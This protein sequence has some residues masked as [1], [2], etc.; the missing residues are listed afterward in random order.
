[1]DFAD[2]N[3]TPGIHP[4]VSIFI[5][6]HLAV[7]PD[8]DLLSGFEVLQ[9][10]AAV[11]IHCATEPCRFLVFDIL[12]VNPFFRMGNGERHE[13]VSVCVINAGILPD[14]SN[15]FNFEHDVF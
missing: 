9:Q 8:K 5:Q 6:L 14:V 2:T 12:I 1:L 7:T 11:T 4:M 3:V 10:S 15:D 13:L